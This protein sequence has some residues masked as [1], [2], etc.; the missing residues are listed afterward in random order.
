MCVFKG[1]NYISIQAFQAIDYNFVIFL[2]LGMCI[3]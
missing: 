2:N 3:G 1:I